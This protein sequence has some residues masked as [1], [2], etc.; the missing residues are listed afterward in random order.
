MVEVGTLEAERPLVLHSE[1]AAL[2]QPCT[3]LGAGGRLQYREHD[4]ALVHFA[5]L[6]SVTRRESLSSA[7]HR[8]NLVQ[9]S[10]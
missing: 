9:R 4:N 1:I 5:L 2:G 3:A 6:F 10:F 7:E 8:V